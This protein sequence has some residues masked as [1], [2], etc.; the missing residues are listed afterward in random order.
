[1]SDGRGWLKCSLTNLEARAR[2]S[3]TVQVEDARGN[4]G[5]GQDPCFTRINK[6]PPRRRK[7]GDPEPEIDQVRHCL[8]AL[9]YT[10]RT[11]ILLTR[12]S[13]PCL[14]IS[15]PENSLSTF[16]HRT[17]NTNTQCLEKS[18]PNPKLRRSAI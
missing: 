17:H 18:R 5:A 16:A 2:P 12:F 6:L 4:T 7:L 8:A 3:E 15:R 13:A 1:M 11:A 10:Q 9:R 14:R